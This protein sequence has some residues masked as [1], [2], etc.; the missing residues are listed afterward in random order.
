MRSLFKSIPFVV[1]L[2]LFLPHHNIS[3]QVP[4]ATIVLLSRADSAAIRLRWA[5]TSA[6]AW[7]RGNKAGFM[8]EKLLLAQGST[9]LSSPRFIARYP[10]KLKAVEAW[11]TLA[12]EKQQQRYAGIALQAIYGKRF[13]VESAGNN[14]F[15]AI[16]TGMQEQEM[17]YSFAM[18][19]ADYSFPVAEAMGVGFVDNAVKKGEKY[20]YKVYMLSAAGAKPDTAFTLAGVD[21]FRPLPVPLE[22]NVQFGDHAATV[23]WNTQ[24]HEHIYTG[25]FI[26]RSDDGRHFKRLSEI[27]VTRPVKDNQR[28][29]DKI[30][31]KTDSLAHNDSPVYYRVVGLTPFG[32]SGPPSGIVSGKGKASFA[33][34]PVFERPR[35]HN[36]LVDFR[37]YFPDEKDRALSRIKGFAIERSVQTDGI[38]ESVYPELLS[39]AARTASDSLLRG[40]WYYRL[41]I[42]DTNDQAF[43]SFAQLVL[44]PDSI[45][46]AIPTGLTGV[47]DSTGKVTLRWKKVTDDDVLGYKV[48][49]SNHRNT[50]YSLITPSPVND[51]SLVDSLDLNTLTNTIYYRIAAV[52]KNYNHS[53]FSA[54]VEVVKPDKIRPA[55]P[56]LSKVSRVDNTIKIEWI[57]SSSPDVVEHHVYRKED[58]QTAWDLLE[59]VPVSDHV[60]SALDQ[61]VQAGK[62]YRYTVLAVDRGKLESKPSNTLAV[63]VPR[64][65]QKLTGL[66]SVFDPGTGEVMISW[67]NRADVK[68]YWIYRSVNDESLVLRQKQNAVNSFKD[69]LTQPGKYT[70]RIKVILQGDQPAFFSGP[71]VVTG[72]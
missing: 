11:E 9:M 54:D 67:D 43:Y 30:I 6:V 49:R 65:A 14:N 39:S 21:D 18:M 40:S 8:V 10:V 66:K 70:Y 1:T 71:V 31:Y 35:I 60:A 34:M 68:Y 22:V 23:S 15:S 69:N 55:A 33:A 24:Y 32:D 13:D 45:P 27:P 52:D 47:A 37:W 61:T 20:L 12:R 4:P 41:K 53:E 72:K 64:E 7:Q 25:Y 3:A 17:R 36:R 62:G 56:V 46:P 51:V 58:S 19:S 44:A 42:V 28:D 57:S 48:F 16:M 26:E 2:F 5:P 63:K 50:E 59:I 38:F 29:A